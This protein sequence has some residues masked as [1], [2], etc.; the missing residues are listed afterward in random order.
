MMFKYIDVLGRSVFVYES[1]TEHST[2]RD[3]TFKDTHGI[4]IENKLSGQ[5]VAIINGQVDF[6]INDFDSFVKRVER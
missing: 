2:F 6:D 1:S 5:V 4:Y 3:Y